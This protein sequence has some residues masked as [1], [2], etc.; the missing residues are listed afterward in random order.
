[1]LGAFGSGGGF[2]MAYSGLNARIVKIETQMESLAE[3]QRE[4]NVL[5]QDIETLLR[6]RPVNRR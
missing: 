3:R 6:E 5:L 1:M 4:N 2:Y